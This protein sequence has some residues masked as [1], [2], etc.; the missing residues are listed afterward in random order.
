MKLASSAVVAR[1]HSPSR[2]TVSVHALRLLDL[3]EDGGRGRVRDQHH[4]HRSVAANRNKFVSVFRARV[5]EKSAGRGT[6]SPARRHFCAKCG[7]ALWVWDPRWPEFVYP[8]A[9]AIDTKLPKPA[10]EVEIM[11]DY[12]APWSEIPRGQGHTHFRDTRR[13]HRGLARRGLTVK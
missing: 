6:L 10:E 3:P 11:L 5:R 4:G 7:S 12:A 1:S 2:R 9:S 13:R 8:F